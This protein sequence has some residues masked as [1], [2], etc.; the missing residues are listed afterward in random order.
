M[1]KNKKIILT[2]VILIF[3]SFFVFA[4]SNGIWNDAKDIQGGI[5]GGDEQ[6]NT[7]N[8][9]FINN[10]TFNDFVLIQSNLSIFGNLENNGILNFAYLDENDKIYRFELPFEQ[11]DV[12]SP[13]DRS[14]ISTLPS[15]ENNYFN[16]SELGIGGNLGNKV[17]EGTNFGV[18]NQIQGAFSLDNICAPIGN[19]NCGVTSILTAGSVYTKVGSDS[20][21]ST[22][23]C[24]RL[25]INSNGLISSTILKSAGICKQISSCTSSSQVVSNYSDGTSCDIGKICSGGDC[26]QVAECNYG[27]DFTSVSIS[28]LNNVGGVSLSNNQKNWFRTAHCIIGKANSKYKVYGQSLITVP[29]VSE[30]LVEGKTCVINYLGHGN[31]DGVSDVARLTYHDAWKLDV[32]CDGVNIVNKWYSGHSMMHYDSDPI[33]YSTFTNDAYRVSSIIIGY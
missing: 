32:T 31:N 25:D 13:T 17:I 1:E 20:P 2:F 23:Y 22:N 33:T 27:I 29:G 28:G 7:I 24:N 10:V 8:Y 19:A 18:N 4:D 30:V 15:Y 11:G 6:L 16:I 26:K 3:S 14:S 5:I 9:S 12:I 21:T